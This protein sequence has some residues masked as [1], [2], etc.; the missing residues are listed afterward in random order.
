MPRN[1]EIKAVINN[2]ASFLLKAEELSGAAGRTFKQVD[3]FFE[4]PNGRLK[5]R[6]EEVCFYKTLNSIYLIIFNVMLA[7]I[8]SLL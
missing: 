7:C 6:E 3:T 8:K 5:F 4:V 2:F 1:V